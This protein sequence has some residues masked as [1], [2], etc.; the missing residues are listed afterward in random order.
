MKEPNQRFDHHAKEI[1]ARKEINDLLCCSLIGEVIIHKRLNDQRQQNI[2]N[3]QQ[4]GKKD[5]RIKRFAEG[6]RKNEHP[7]D[8]RFLFFE[9]N[10][11]TPF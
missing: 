5:G 6:F 3:R 2:D 8:D 9:R 11:F 1:Q 7:L 4:Q 10:R